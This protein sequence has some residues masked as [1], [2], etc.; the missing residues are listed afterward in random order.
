VQGHPDDAPVGQ[1]LRELRAVCAFF[2]V[3]GTYPID[4]H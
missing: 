4:V 3:L 2:K 1:A